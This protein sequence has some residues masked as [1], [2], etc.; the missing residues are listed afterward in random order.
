[1]HVLINARN[2]NMTNTVF[3]KNSFIIHLIVLKWQQNGQTIIIWPLKKSNQALFFF[4]FFFLISMTASPDEDDSSLPA[5]LSNFDK[6]I[7]SS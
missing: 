7:K 5:L 2:D 4:F 3:S 6:F 1:M